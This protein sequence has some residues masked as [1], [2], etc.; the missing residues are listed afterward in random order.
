MSQRITYP[1]VLLSRDDAAAYL[2]GISVRKLDALQAEG[3]V[4][5]AALDGRRV[6]PREELDK[7][8]AALPEWVARR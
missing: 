2:G 1:P 7:F 6:Y 4:I 5:P 8:A 3:R